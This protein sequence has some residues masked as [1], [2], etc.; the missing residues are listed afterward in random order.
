MKRVLPLLAVLALT[1]FTAAPALMAADAPKDA[2]KDAV[3]MMVPEGAKATKPF[4]LFPHAN[5]AALD[6]KACHHKW[7]GT[8][9]M[10]ACKASGCHDDVSTKKG[11][12][13]YYLAYHKKT[14][15]SCLGCHKALKK[16]GAEKYGPF[17][18]NGCHKKENK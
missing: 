7:D 4:V 5:H 16:E 8:S 9:E 13:A 14:K 10:Q 6:C 1:A 15:Q 12:R 3:K 17:A 18:C 2:P 11:D